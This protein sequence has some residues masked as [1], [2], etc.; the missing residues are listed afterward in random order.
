MEAYDIDFKIADH[1]NPVSNSPFALVKMYPK[2]DPVTYSRRYMLFRRHH[3]YKIYEH[4][5]LNI[6]EFLQL[7]R[8]YVEL[9]LKLG[10][11]YSA[12]K[13]TSQSEALKA[14][15]EAEAAAAQRGQH[16]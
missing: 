13:S 14:V 9:Y 1:N 15:K 12:E 16:K 4:F 5:G 6:A 3:I 2:E 8:E 11:E 7:P 10:A